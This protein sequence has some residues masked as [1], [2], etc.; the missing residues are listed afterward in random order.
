M[1]FIQD[2]FSLVQVLELFIKNIQ[3]LAF[4]GKI[5][6][7]KE[8]HLLMQ[9]ELKHYLKDENEIK[10]QHDS[11]RAYDEFTLFISKKYKTE[12]EIE[13]MREK[14]FFFLTMHFEKEE[15]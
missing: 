6:I 12:R 4:C 5:L 13:W 9:K 7:L 3:N 2:N 10:L 11:Q 1:K 14:F 15:R 8:K